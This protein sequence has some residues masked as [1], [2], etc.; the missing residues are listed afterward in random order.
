MNVENYTSQKGKQWFIV[1]TVDGKIVASD[2][3]ELADAFVQNPDSVVLE[4]PNKDGGWWFIEG[5]KDNGTETQ[6]YQSQTDLKDNINDV[7]NRLQEI[8]NRL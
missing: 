2:K 7:I 3:R 6:N 1:R 5:L 4:H 8:K